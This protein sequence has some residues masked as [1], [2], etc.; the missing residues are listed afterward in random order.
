[1][2]KRTIWFYGSL[3]ILSVTMGLLLTGSPL[4]TRALDSNDTIPLGTFITWAGMI[5]LPMAI[6]WGIR[7]LRRP[8]SKL[9]RVLSLF[10]KIILVL[11]ILWVPIS[12]LLSGNI[13]FSFSEKDEFQG[14]QLAMRLFWAFSYGIPIG[15]VSLLILYWLSLLIRKRK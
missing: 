7:E 3:V 9:N 13:S 15:S 4:L 12:Y 10:L 14:G 6:Y 2:N 1:M 5:S 8:L 11:A